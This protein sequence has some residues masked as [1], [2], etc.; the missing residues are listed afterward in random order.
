M[1]EIVYPRNVV[2]VSCSEIHEVFG[3]QIEKDN[4]FA[5]SWHTPLSL[6]PEMYAISVSKE[7]FSLELIKKSKCFCV[8]FL[9]FSFKE[10]VL[11]CGRNSGRHLDKFQNTRFSK[12]DCDN[13]D[14]IRIKE[15][16]SFLECEVVEE[17]EVGDHVLLISKVVGK[18]LI[19]ND[20]KI[21]QVK[22]DIFTTTL[23]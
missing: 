2:L 21:F 12:E 19:S 11:F 3:K 16:S 7:S 1:K 20:K 13:I 18:S 15:A 5:V 23:D 4:L 6:N 14:C 17:I 8:N 22:S 9:S 10:D